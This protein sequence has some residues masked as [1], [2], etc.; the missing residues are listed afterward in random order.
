MADFAYLV[1]V[2]WWPPKSVTVRR[3]FV[4]LAMSATT[5][6]RNTSSDTSLPARR[7]RRSSRPAGWEAKRRRSLQRRRVRF[8]SLEQRLFLSGAAERYLFA[9]EL[10]AD[11]EQT[12]PGLVGTYIDRSLADLT[13]VDDWRISQP[14]AGTRVDSPLEFLS[15]G[16]GSL[17][18]V[19]LTGG[20]DADWERFSVQWDG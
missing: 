1:T 5:H 3:F 6:D 4:D 17:A 18:S 20:S 9:A 11:A 12:R 7:V 8:E 10:Y 13:G 14:V 15:N 2:S 16:W 19:G